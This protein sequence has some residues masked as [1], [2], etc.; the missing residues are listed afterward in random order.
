MNQPA[1]WL[2]EVVAIW[3]SQFKTLVVKVDTPQAIVPAVLITFFP[4]AQWVH[5]VLP[6][7]SVVYW[8]QSARRVAAFPHVVIPE[9]EIRADNDPAQWVQI[10]APDAEIVYWS[11]F[12]TRLDVIIPQVAPVLLIITFSP[13]AQWVQMLVPPV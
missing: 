2:Q 9:L 6:A 4:F 7:E 5:L 12:G 11:Q 1:Q 13:L 10:W 8:S 3:L